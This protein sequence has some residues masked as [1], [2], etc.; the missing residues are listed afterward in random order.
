MTEFAGMKNPD[1]CHARLEIESVV[2]ELA[3]L[4]H[5]RIPTPDNGTCW[6]MLMGTDD[7]AAWPDSDGGDVGRRSRPAG[8]QRAP[9]PGPTGVA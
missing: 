1:G 9:Q 7:E 6:R 2:D 3:P 5:E 4:V 8:L